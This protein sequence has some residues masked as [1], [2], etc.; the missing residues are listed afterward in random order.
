MKSTTKLTR[1][2]SMLINS[3]NLE[4]DLVILL[5]FIPLGSWKYS[6]SGAKEKIEAD[7]N[8]PI[9]NNTKRLDTNNLGKEK[10]ENFTKDEY[11]ENI[12]V[13]LIEF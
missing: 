6:I 8:N 5:L 7:S 1:L 2:G 13:L 4:K 9:I 3:K 10:I 12:L 11:L